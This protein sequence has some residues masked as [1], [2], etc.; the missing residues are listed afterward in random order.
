MFSL[1][2]K[3]VC[4]IFFQYFKN[5][6]PF[7]QTALVFYQKSTINIIQIIFLIK[8]KNHSFTFKMFSFSLL[9]QKLGYDVSWHGFVQFYLICG[10]LSLLSI[11]VNVFCQIWDIFSHYFFKYFFSSTVFLVSWDPSDMYIRSFVIEILLFIS[12]YFLFI[13]QFG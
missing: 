6:L 9:F 12:V 7:P 4:V 11:Q 10:L 5:I 2:I 3:L 8:V 13:V 1:S